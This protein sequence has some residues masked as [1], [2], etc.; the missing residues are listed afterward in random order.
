MKIY[1]VLQDDAL[2]TCEVTKT[3][4]R[5]LGIIASKSVAMSTRRKILSSCYFRHSMQNV[6]YLQKTIE[7]SI[8]YRSAGDSLVHKTFENKCFESLC[9]VLDIAQVPSMFHK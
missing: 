2:F 9:T 7:K 3:V 1:I 5:K 8:D 6:F 4:Y